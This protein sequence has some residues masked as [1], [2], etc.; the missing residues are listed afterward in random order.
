MISFLVLTEATAA[1][2]G[3]GIAAAASLAGA[4]VSAWSKKKTEERQN[5]YNLD[6]EARQQ[7]YINK[8][9]AY[10]SPVSQMDRFRA[11]GLNPYIVDDAGNQSDSGSSIANTAA[12]YSDE[13]S[14]AASGV[15]TA[16]LSGAAAYRQSMKEEKQYQLDMLRLNEQIRQYDETMK[17]TQFQFDYKAEVDAANTAYN[18]ARD[19]VMDEFRDRELKVKEGGLS[20]EQQ[21]VELAKIESERSA[22]LAELRDARE[23]QIH[24][25]RVEAMTTENA[26]NRD[27]FNF[28]KDY[29]LPNKQ[30]AAKLEGFILHNRYE[31][32]QKLWHL[33][34]TCRNLQ[35]QRADNSLSQAQYE[36]KLYELWD[37]LHLGTISWYWTSGV[38]MNNPYE[39]NRH[40]QASPFEAASR[41]ILLKYLDGM[42][43]LAK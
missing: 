12:D 23:A 33:D 2:I 13:A 37:S 7:S 22:R 30:D 16:G 15:A 31:D 38:G 21:K 29:E 26:Y 18:H 5:A 9:N 32:R 42:F 3:S 27:A 17:E 34:E 41:G 40:G 28:W 11:A 25:L 43:Q 14:R 10:N 4:G 24:S 19:N 8:Q 35:Q 1:L 36:G 20:V 39:E 6:A